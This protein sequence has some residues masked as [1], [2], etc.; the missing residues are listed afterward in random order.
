MWPCR[1]ADTLHGSNTWYCFILILI[2]LFSFFSKTNTE[3]GSFRVFA[4]REWVS[5]P[6][7]QKLSYW[8]S[9]N[10]MCQCGTQPLIK[11]HLHKR[12]SSTFLPYCWS[13]QCASKR[14]IHL[15]VMIQCGTDD[16]LTAVLVLI[17]IKSI[18]ICNILFSFEYML[19]SLYKELI[20]IT[21]CLICK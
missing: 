5:R 9:K 2:Y 6:L 16:I 20:M 13:I 11:R 17:I 12:T 14:F 10:S 1:C 15:R 3:G 4:V 8:L 7:L 18:Y 19:I 21:L